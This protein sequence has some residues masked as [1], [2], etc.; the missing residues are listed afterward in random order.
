MNDIVGNGVM[1]APLSSQQSFYN[2]SFCWDEG[3]E[4]EVTVSRVVDDGPQ[5]ITFELDSVSSI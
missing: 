4:Y 5:D 2:I 3:T 1:P